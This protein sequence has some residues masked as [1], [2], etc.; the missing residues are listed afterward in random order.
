MLL[1]MA[2]TMCM[3]VFMPKLMDS[4][5]PEE[6]KRMEDQMAN[7]SDP[8]KMLKGLFG[9]GDDEKSD[10]EEESRGKKKRK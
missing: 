6:R 1:M 10:S 8:Q 9:M 2:F 4:L 3:V 7:S 5:E